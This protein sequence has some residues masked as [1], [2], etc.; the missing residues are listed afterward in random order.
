MNTLYDQHGRRKY[1]TSHGTDVFLKSADDAEVREVR[2]F[3]GTLVCRMP[4]GFHDIVNMVTSGI[5]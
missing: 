1:L 3:C 5:W 2:I 4:T